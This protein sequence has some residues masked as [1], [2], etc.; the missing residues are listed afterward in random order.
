MTLTVTP[1]TLQR[2]TILGELFAAAPR[3]VSEDDCAENIVVPLLLRLGYDRLQLRRKVTIPTSAS[4]VRKQADIVVF[5]DDEPAIV[6][7]TKR[8]SHRLRE[9]DANQVLSYAQLLDPPV[10]LAVLTNGESWEVYDLVADSVATLDELPEAPDLP[11]HPAVRK[12][13]LV[14]SEAREAAERLL[15]TIENKALLETAFRRCRQLLAREGLIAESAFDELTKILVCKFNEEKT[16]ADG[17]GPYRFSSS[18]LTG[19]GPI[20]GLSRMFNDAKRAFPVFPPNT[21]LRIRDNTTASSIVAAL[22]PFAFYGF[23]TPLG[24][25]GAGGDVVGSVYETFLSGTLRGDLGQYLTPRQLIDFMVELADIQL[26][27]RVLDLSCGSG[28][29]L[30]RAFQELRKKIRLQQG[31]EREK[32]RL[33]AE[34]VTDQLWGIEINER[35]ATLCRINLILHGDGFEHVYAGDSIA[36]DVFE[37]TGGRRI[38]LRLIEQGELP[39]FDVILMN[40]PFNLPYDDAAVLNRYELGRGR[41]SQGSDYL[42]LERALRLLK[43]ESGRLLIVLPH[44]VA[45]GATEQDVRRFI[46][47]N[48]RIKACISLPVGAFKPFGGSNAR[49]CIPFLVKQTASRGQ[50]RFLAQAET[51]GYDVSS[52]YYSPTDANDLLIIADEYHAA[53]EGLS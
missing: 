41:T 38:D 21:Q 22:E 19:E 37:N 40:P 34:I 50:L 46:R 27:D 10:N 35:L 11:T 30:I 17:L 24:L 16:F 9:E 32:R 3:M 31:D 7:E 13:R 4:G 23:R 45:S 6:I 18:W 15:V 48:S 33:L 26:G 12:S 1:M 14:T 43:E 36:G 44:G 47:R 53:I 28:G 49:T 20:T 2:R 52:K 29:F 8:L 42:M 39:K 51:V 25:A 5:L